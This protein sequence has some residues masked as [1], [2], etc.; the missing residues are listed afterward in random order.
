MWAAC[1]W[2]TDS[3]HFSIFVFRAR[4]LPVLVYSPLHTPT[5]YF[6]LHA[7]GIV[8]LGVCCFWSIEVCFS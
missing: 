5:G 2:G 1:G 7:G 3:M 4:E 8:G 6:I